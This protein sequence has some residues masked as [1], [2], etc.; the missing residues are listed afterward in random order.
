M[1]S[2]YYSRDLCENATSLVNL[3]CTMEQSSHG[4]RGNSEDATMAGPKEIFFFVTLLTLLNIITHTF[5]NQKNYRYLPLIVGVLKLGYTILS[6]KP[7]P[8]FRI[9]K[10]ASSGAVNKVQVCFEDS[11]QEGSHVGTASFCAIG[12]K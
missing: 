5:S 3:T 7:H 10:R 9:F 1:K 8:H 11:S 2:L 6:A 12:V 4:M